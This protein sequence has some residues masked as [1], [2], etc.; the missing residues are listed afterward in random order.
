M[1]KQKDYVEKKTSELDKWKSELEDLKGMAKST[2]GA[3]KAKLDGQM[4]ELQ[5]LR[6]EAGDRLKQALEAS[7]G[8]WETVRDDV[9]HTW[10]AFRHSVNYFKSHF[11]ERDQAPR[12]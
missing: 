5:R 4:H 12:Q 11:K 3:L 6:G 10:K 2:S 7:E 8:T 1:S 9:E